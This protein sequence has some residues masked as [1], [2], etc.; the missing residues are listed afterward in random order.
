MKNTFYIAFG[1]ANTETRNFLVG[2]FST[3]DS[4]LIEIFKNEK[5]NTS[6]QPTLT[7]YVMNHPECYEGISSFTSSL[8]YFA[9]GCFRAQLLGVYIE[10][11]EAEQRVQLTLDQFSKSNKDN[12]RYYNECY[13]LCETIENEV[14]AKEQIDGLGERMKAKQEEYE[15]VPKSKSE[16]KKQSITIVERETG[17]EYQ[18]ETKGDCME[19]L[20]C[21]SDTFSRFL[22]GGTKLIKKYFVKEG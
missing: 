16:V 19:W 15:S 10:K 18:F 21:A 3:E 6:A 9:A 20:D 8:K 14:A 13:N 11:S 2:T 5:M 12:H 1:V 7:E 22:K 4:S 17:K